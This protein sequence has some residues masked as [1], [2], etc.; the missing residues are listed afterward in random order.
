MAS[1]EAVVFDAY[2]TLFDVHSV[3]SRAERLFPG[4]GEALSRL[5]RG[6][7]LEYTWLRSL[8]GTYVDFDRVTA[9]SLRHACEAL[10]L[11]G[12]DHATRQL[13]DQYTHLDLFPD[14]RGAMTELEPRRLAIL[15]NGTPASLE[16]LVRNADLTQTFAAVLSVDEVGSF[17]PDMRVYELAARRLGLR[18]EQIGFVSANC[19]DAIGART[20]GFT[21]FWVNRGGAPLDLHG[22]RPDHVIPS[23]A[24]LPGAVA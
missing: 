16:A 5:W 3:V 17:K 2:G 18:S 19:W 23:L 13:L 11:A 4:R 21:A 12:E 14:A 6:K 10:E 7:Q 24:E 8:M 15:S 9:E 22:P 1:L 20:Y